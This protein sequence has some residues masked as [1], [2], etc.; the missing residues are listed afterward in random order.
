MVYK[1]GRC[2]DIDSA[3]IIS[4]TV[5]LTLLMMTAESM[6]SKHRVSRINVPLFFLLMLVQFDCKQN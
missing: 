2:D 1:T 6:L 3:V 5:L 4:N